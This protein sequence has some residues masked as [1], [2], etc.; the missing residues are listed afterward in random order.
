MSLGKPV[1]PGQR[2]KA[3]LDH[4]FDR[5]IE[6]VEIADHKGDIGGQRWLV[7]N[8][9]GSCIVIGRCTK[10]REDTISEAFELCTK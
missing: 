10:M 1:K 9:S 6:I 3:R 4:D 5:V 2:Y 7:K 8:V